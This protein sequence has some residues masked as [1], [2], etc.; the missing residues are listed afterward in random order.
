MGSLGLYRPKWSL[1]KEWPRRC[2]WHPEAR[3]KEDSPLTQASVPAPAREAIAGAVLLVAPAA[4]VLL[5]WTT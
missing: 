4:F 1:T 5:A 2:W 3:P